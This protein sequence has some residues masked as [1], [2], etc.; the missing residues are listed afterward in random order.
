MNNLLLNL[1]KEFGSAFKVSF[2]ISGI[3]LEQ[4]EAYAPEVLESFKQLAKTGNVE[5]LAE[6]YAHSLSSLIDKEEFIRQ[7]EKH[8]N[9]IEELFGQKPSTFRNTELIYS[10][11]IG[12][13]VADMGYNMML[14][15]G[16]KHVL[17]WRSP[18]LMYAS[19]LTQNL[20]YY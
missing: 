17:G 19:A 15:E 4:F 6:T 1:I 10:D 16:A 8:Q 20:N 18:N 11:E 5:F 7:V 9:R 12:E 2:S 3:A 13:T 14:T